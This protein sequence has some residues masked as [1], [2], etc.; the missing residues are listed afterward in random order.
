MGVS[1][2]VESRARSLVM[3][4]S[5]W[6]TSHDEVLSSC[7]THWSEPVPVRNIL[8]EDRMESLAM[9]MLYEWIRRLFNILTTTWPGIPDVCVYSFMCV[10]GPPVE[11]WSRSVDFWLRNGS[12]R[13]QEKGEGRGG[14]ARGGSGDL[15]ASVLSQQ[16]N[17]TT[18]RHWNNQQFSIR[19][20]H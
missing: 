18:P 17:M 4:M 2:L 19:Y 13:I 15:L 12:G 1:G 3:P 20:T 16:L 14:G 11:W 5:H 8:W 10:C 6:V 7:D 9:S